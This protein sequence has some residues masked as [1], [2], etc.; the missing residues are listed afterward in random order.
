MKAQ[1][2]GPLGHRARLRQRF[3][4][5]GL[6]SFA[7]HE[8]LE[9]LLTLAIPQ[10]DVKPQAKRLLER[11][12]SL[13]GVFDA[14]PEALREVPGIGEAASMALKLIRQAGEIYLR[15]EA[16]ER[17]SFGSFESLQKFWKLRLGGLPHEEFH[18]AY[19]DSSHRLLKD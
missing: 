14:A 13:R 3:I 1:E 16:Q 11:F 17:V 10:R 15:E 2:P 8:A 9:I 4:H 6:E 5:S 19:L 7:P 12:G 18:A